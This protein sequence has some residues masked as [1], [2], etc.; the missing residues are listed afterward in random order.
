[1][2]VGADGTQSGIRQLLSIESAQQHYGQTAIVTNALPSQAH[3]NI[4]YERFT[5]AGPLAL[6]PMS[7]NR[8]GIVLTVEP[9]AQTHYLSMSDAD[10]IQELHQRIGYR[11][12]RFSKI[13]KRSS[14]PLVLMQAERIVGERVALIGNAA[15][16]LH[17]I[18]GQGFNLGLRDIALLVDLLADA[19]RSQADIGSQTLLQDYTDGRHDDVRS[20]T[21]FTDSLAWLFSNPLQTVGVLRS[22]GLFLTDLLPGLRSRIARHSMGLRGRQARLSLGLPPKL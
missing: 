22:T 11:V 5:P 20:M 21:R 4:A 6:L 1:L 9:D 12:G 7:E 15:H 19:L 2:L 17:P 18:S 16:A 8:F 14:Y 13:G 3:H 10:F